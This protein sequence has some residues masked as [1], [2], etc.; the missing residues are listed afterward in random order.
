MRIRPFCALRPPY[1]LA[2]RLACVPYDT[3]TTE[4]ARALAEKNPQSFLHVVCPEIDLS[5]DEHLNPEAAPRKARENLDFFRQQGWLILE[6]SP[7]FYVYCLSREG[8]TQHGIAA[9]VSVR[10]Y[11]HGQIRPH[12]QTRFEKEEDRRR[13]IE[14]TGA[15]TEPLLLAY[16]DHPA[17]DAVVARAEQGSPLLDF[18][19]PDGVRHTL[20]ELGEQEALRDAFRDVSAVYIADG[21]HRA[22]AAARVAHEKRRACTDQGDEEEYNWFL[23]TLFPATQ[24]RIAPYHRCVRSLNGLTPEQFLAVLRQRFHVEKQASSQPPGQGSVSIYLAGQWYGLKW[25]PGEG[26]DPLARL[27]AVRLQERV[28]GP[29]LGI[30][31]PQTDPRIECVGGADRVAELEA[32]VQSG[33]AAVAFSLHPVTIQT[34][35]DIC[36]SGR[37]LPPKSTWFEPKLRS[38][39]FLHPF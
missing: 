7:R 36:D 35:M 8:H 25:P 15:H 17:I 5:S 38:G 37:L 16:R 23:V 32:W 27:D 9:C 30:T 39:L 31:D 4:E 33:R 20:W 14:A 18:V 3:V 11:D 29:I 21:H 1:D 22:A 34:V 28:L 10:D 6:E 13:H 19:A 12:E 2:A 26:N 24:L